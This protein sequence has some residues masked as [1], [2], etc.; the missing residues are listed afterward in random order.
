MCQSYGCAY[1]L[2]AMYV[3]PATGLLKISTVVT[4]Y[5]SVSLHRSAR[6]ILLSDEM[7]VMRLMFVHGVV[8]GTSCSDYPV[9]RLHLMRHLLLGRCIAGKFSGCRSFAKAAQ[10][11]G[12]FP[13]VFC[14]ASIV[15]SGVINN[16]GADVLRVHTDF[17]TPQVTRNIRRRAKDGAAS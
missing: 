8:V 9:L 11:A 6:F 13:H 17:F 2:V 7:T 10:D 12:V 14:I 15:H 3:V 5:H 16:V 1:M 4:M